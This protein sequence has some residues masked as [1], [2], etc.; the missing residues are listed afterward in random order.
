MAIRLPE[1]GRETHY[2]VRQTAWIL[3][4]HPAQ[5]SRAVRLGAL[6]VRWHEGSPRI[7]ATELVRLLGEHGYSAAGGDA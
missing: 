6:R 7:P 4:V 5:V 2:T 1:S 3:G